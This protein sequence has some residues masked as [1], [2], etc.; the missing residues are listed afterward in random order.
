MGWRVYPAPGG[1]EEWRYILTRRGACVFVVFGEG[2]RLPREGE[3]L[4][5]STPVYR[6]TSYKSMDYVLIKIGHLKTYWNDWADFT[7]LDW[8][9]DGAECKRV[10]GEYKSLLKQLDQG[11]V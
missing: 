7:G 9:E 2:E 10:A 6:V 5:K 11:E 3:D 1:G 4:Y 8:D